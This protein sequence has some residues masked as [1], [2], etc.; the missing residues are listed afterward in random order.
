MA[1]PPRHVAFYYQAARQRNRDAPDAVPQRG[2]P[3]FRL[4]TVVG[5]NVRK[6]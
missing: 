3:A 6:V 5:C 1:L 4:G 2:S